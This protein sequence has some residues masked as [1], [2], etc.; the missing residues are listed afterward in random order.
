MRLISVGI[1]PTSAESEHVFSC[2]G[3]IVVPTRSCEKVNML[4]FLN[5]NRSYI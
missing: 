2:A 3:N 1:P 4:I 5:K